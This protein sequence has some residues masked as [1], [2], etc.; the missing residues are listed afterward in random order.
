MENRTFI[1]KLSECLSIN[2][3]LSYLEIQGRNKYKKDTR[4][5]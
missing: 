1:L 3:V 2:Y 4:Q 5:Y